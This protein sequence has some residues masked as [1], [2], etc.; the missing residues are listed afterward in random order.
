MPPT[1]LPP[2]NMD[3]TPLCNTLVLGSH[4]SQDLFQTRELAEF[5]PASDV[6]TIASPHQT[7][8]VWK[9]EKQKL[10]WEGA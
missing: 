2:L 6:S 4:P 3:S 7:P 8:L 10:T 9:S 1:V 5:R